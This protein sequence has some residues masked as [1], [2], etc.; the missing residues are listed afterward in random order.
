MDPVRS[1]LRTPT[2][3]SEPRACPVRRENAWQ[4]T[5]RE[6]DSTGLY[7]FRE[8]FY[9]PQ[10]QRFISEDPLG[11]AGGM[12]LFAY[13]DNQPTSYID[14]FGLKPSPGLG[15]PP[16]GRGPRPGNPPGPRPGNPPRPRP[17]DKPNPD[18]PDKPNRC[19][20]PARV[21]KGNQ[22]TVWKQGGFPGVLVAPGSGVIIPSQFGM[23]K[24]A[25]APYI[26]GISGTFPSGFPLFNGVT[27]VIGGESPIPG[28]GVRQAL[29]DIYPDQFIVE[30]PTGD[31]L[32]TIPVIISVPAG[33]SCPTGTSPM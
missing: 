18:D 23:T 1:K 27:D 28:V 11:A 24:G 21:L 17:G 16:G 31:D 13:A 33:V 4:F 6:N 10:L 8:R 19:A 14:P 20:G 12:N 32:G 5:G 30:L 15:Q 22:R 9:N 29:Q 2:T 26:G 3:P 25:L 7:Y